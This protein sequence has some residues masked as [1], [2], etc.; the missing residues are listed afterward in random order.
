MNMFYV[1][2]PT[3]TVKQIEKLMI[4]EK[5]KL[6][7]NYLKDILFQLKI[8]EDEF[9]T[10]ET[11]VIVKDFFYKHEELIKEDYND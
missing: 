10:E 1:D 7:N 8:S 11:K 6:S 3:D 2:A 5:F 9:D 4:E